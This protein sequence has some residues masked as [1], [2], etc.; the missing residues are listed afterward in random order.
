MSFIYWQKKCEDCVLDGDCL[1][2]QNGD[3]NVHRIKCVTI[4]E[5]NIFN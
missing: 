3:V 2:Q 1:F 5:A 4:V